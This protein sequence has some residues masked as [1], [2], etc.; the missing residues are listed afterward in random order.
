MQKVSSLE[1]QKELLLD[2]IDEVSIEKQ[3]KELENER[4][5][6]ELETEQELRD[7]K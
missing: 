5:S 6:K 1:G 3:E 2:K 4:L 7:K